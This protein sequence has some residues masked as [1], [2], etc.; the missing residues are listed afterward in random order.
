MIYFEILVPQSAKNLSLFKFAEK[1]K[2]NYESKS[3]NLAKVGPLSLRVG[4]N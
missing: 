1:V 4:A 3:T 2:L